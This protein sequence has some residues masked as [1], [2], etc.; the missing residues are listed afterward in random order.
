ME[1]VF[2]LLIVLSVT[3]ML[4]VLVYANSTIVIENN[5]TNSESTVSVNNNVSTSSNSSENQTD[6]IMNTNGEIQEYHGNDSNVQMKSRDGQS[7]VSIINDLNFSPLPSAIFATPSA[8]FFPT[9]TPSSTPSAKPKTVFS[10]FD[11]MNKFFLPPFKM[12][13]I[14]ERV[15]KIF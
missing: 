6:V 11:S 10:I 5:R 2:A 13:S 9:A 1:K 7:N 14:F 15:F 12:K 4:P 8:W 3:V